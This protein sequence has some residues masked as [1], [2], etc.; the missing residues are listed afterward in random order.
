MVKRKDPPWGISQKKNKTLHQ[1][2][3]VQILA[4]DTFPCTE[5]RGEKKLSEWFPF[6]EDN[7]SDQANIDGGHIGEFLLSKI[8]MTNEKENDIYL[9]SDALGN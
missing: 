3:H 5:D 8:E 4:S 7:K 2:N 1:F 6:K 9:L